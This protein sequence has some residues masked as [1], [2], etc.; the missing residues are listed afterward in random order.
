MRSANTYERATIVIHGDHGSR[1]GLVDP[2]AT[3]M[4]RLTP[5]DYADAFSILFAVKAPGIEAGID[6]RMLP[7]ASLM[8][9]VAVPVGDRLPV[10]FKPSVFIGERGAAATPFELPAFPALPPQTR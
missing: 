7:L 10:A 2:T 8:S 4:S 9:Y 6:S 5:A 3:T 1:I